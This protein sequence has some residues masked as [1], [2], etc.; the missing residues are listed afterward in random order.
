MWWCATGPLAT[1][2][3]HAAGIYGKENTGP[4]SVISDFVI[5]SYTPTLS[6]LLDRVNNPRNIKEEYKGILLVSQPKTPG[7]S[8]L[9]GTTK[10]TQLVSEQL[11]ED[12]SCVT[13]LD[14]DEATLERVVSEMESHSC[15]H[16]ACH[17][18]QD[19]KPLDSGFYLHDGRLELTEIYQKTI[20]KRRSCLPV[21][22]SDKYWGGCSVGEAVHLAAGMLAA[23]Y[24]GVVATMWS[25][26]DRY[27]PL[28]AESFYREL[29]KYQTSNGSKPEGI[30]SRGAASALHHAIKQLRESLDGSGASLLTWVPY[31]H[32]GL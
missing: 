31:V 12:V 25:I 30:S 20:S 18:I 32:I 16:F 27:G 14:G 11:K 26:K 10:E 21:C 7:L 29:R 6:A 2:P 1:L 5:S 19:G 9:P 8:P 3:I 17:A 4:G 22:L 23:G 15:I 24:R 28:V 13:C